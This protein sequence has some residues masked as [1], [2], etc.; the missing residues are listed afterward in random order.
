MRGRKDL[1]SKRK[2]NITRVGT[3]FGAFEKEKGREREREREIERERGKERKRERERERERERGREG[4][5]TRPLFATWC[6]HAY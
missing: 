3:Q 2:I 4:D 1:G 6:M 5:Q